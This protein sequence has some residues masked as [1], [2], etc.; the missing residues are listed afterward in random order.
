MADLLDTSKFTNGPGYLYVD[1]DLISHTQGG[2]TVSVTPSTRNRTC[3]IY[4][5]SA[6]QVIHQGDDCR[7]TAPL[8]QWTAE[9]LKAVYDP[10]DDQTESGGTDGGFLGIGRTAGYFY[11]TRPV[12]VVPVAS[13]IAHLK[14]AFWRCCPVGQVEIGRAHV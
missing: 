4:G 11:T 6:L 8:A 5:E 2:I 13:N 3:D 1:G 14:T 12:E 9:T 7:I 10:G